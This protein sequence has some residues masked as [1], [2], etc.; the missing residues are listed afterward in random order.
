[1]MKSARFKNC[2]CSGDCIARQLRNVVIDDDDD[3]RFI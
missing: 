3:D 1:M 2:L